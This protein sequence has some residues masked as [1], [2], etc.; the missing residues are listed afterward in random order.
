MASPW[1]A[2]ASLGGT[3]TMTSRSSDGQGVAPT[4]SAQQLLDD[5][6]ALAAT[7]KVRSTTLSTLPGASL[8][9]TDVLGALRWAYTEVA[10][11][12]VGAIVI[13]GTDTIEETAYLLDLYWD[14]PQPLVVT[15]AMRA[16]QTPGA[17]GPANILASVRV[18]CDD[19]SRDRGVLVVMNDQIHAAT[20]VRKTR[21]SGPAAFASTSFGPLG[22]L[23][24]AR[25]VFGHPPVSRQA[26]RLPEAFVAP[27]VAILETY[28]GDDG[29]AL[30]TLAAAGF[31]GLVLAGFGVGH[32]SGSLADAVQTAAAVAPTVLASRTGAGSTHHNSYSFPGSETDLIGRG[33]IPAG[34]LDARKARILLSCLVAASVPTELIRDE[35]DRRGYTI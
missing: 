22:Y 10:A 7:T 4:M 5:L 31:D 26:L 34:W 14:Q 11:G 13:Q 28:L 23:E 17:D 9:F 29:Q 30:R 27:R 15:G 16:P 3:I 19:S 25:P 24:E 6:P 2:V 20:R 8:T 32:V 35:F 12:A 33:V 21:A 18:A 1:I